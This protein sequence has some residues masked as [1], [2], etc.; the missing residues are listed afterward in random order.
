MLV[1]RAACWR[2]AEDAEKDGDGGLKGNSSPDSNIPE[3]IGKTAGMKVGMEAQG[4]TVRQWWISLR[5][6]DP[7]PFLPYPR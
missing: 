6:P 5:I 1:A 2:A 3:Q 7:A 4:D